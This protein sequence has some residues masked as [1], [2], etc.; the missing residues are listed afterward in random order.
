MAFADSS[1][2]RRGPTSD[3]PGASH[4]RR[5]LALLLACL[6][7]GLALS[8]AGLEIFD[9]WKLRRILTAWFC[10]DL[11]WGWYAGLFLGAPLALWIWGILLAALALLAGPLALRVAGLSRAAIRSLRRLLVLAPL[12]VGLA[13]PVILLPAFASFGLLICL[14]AL[15]WLW[16]AAVVLRELVR[17]VPRRAWI[18]PGILVSIV[19]LGLGLGASWILRELKLTSAVEIDLGLEHPEWAP[20]VFA[21]SADGKG[22]LLA[23]V[24]GQVLRYDLETGARAPATERPAEKGFS[25]SKDAAESLT[26]ELSPGGTAV[27]VTAD[28]LDRAWKAHGDKPALA[29][30]VR[31]DGK[32]IATGGD[33]NVIRLWTPAGG[34]VRTL[35]GHSDAVHALAWSR[36]GKRLASASADGTLRVWDVETLRP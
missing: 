12:T 36:D 28:G 11:D 8:I 29:V 34:L 4:A 26:A 35:Y 5:A 15:G 30:A 14:W 31:P 2:A 1:L 17:L 19:F 6:P 20:K 24:A 13:S 18:G 3:G 32:L 27:R 21:F 23:E 9:V 22:V 7:L 33:D 10:H 16:P 25:V